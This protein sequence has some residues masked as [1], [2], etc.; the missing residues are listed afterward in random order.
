MNFS[1]LVAFFAIFAF[2]FLC[3]ISNDQ[4]TGINDDVYVDSVSSHFLAEVSAFDSYIEDNPTAAGDVTNDVI[5]PEWLHKNSSI[6]MI[7][8]SQNSFV[9]M[10]AEKLLLAE[11]MHKTNWSAFIGYTSDSFIITNVGEIA[12][13]SFIP[14][15]YVVYVR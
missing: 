9:Y 3:R 10:P 15:G 12:K 4:I 8:T 5:L 11:L 6:K 1:G 2:A 7:V 13:P 14:S